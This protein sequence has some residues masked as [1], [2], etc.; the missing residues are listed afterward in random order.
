MSGQMRPK[1]KMGPSV[2]SV[3]S[4]RKARRGSGA[5]VLSRVRL[6]AGLS[7]RDLRRIAALAEE[8]WYAP[9]H[10]VVEEGTQG[11]AFFAILDGS[12]RV[13][14]GGSDRT[15]R[16][17]GPG[18]SFGELALLDGGPRSATVTAETSLDAVRI[19]RT[20][21]HRLLR[22]EPEVGIRIMASLAGWIRECEGRT[23]G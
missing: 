1:P 7:Q 15:L 9:G 10:V 19:R 17:L 21:F 18:D 8:V 16:T 23:L 22:R 11:T 20:E 12:A 3:Q 13:T 2:G 6:F 5:R 14:R 4:L